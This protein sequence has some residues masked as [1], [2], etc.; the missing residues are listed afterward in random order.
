MLGS[1]I[2]LDTIFSAPA[3]CASSNLKVMR[4]YLEGFVI[5]ATMHHFSGLRRKDENL[6]IG[7]NKR[8][9]LLCPVGRGGF[10]CLK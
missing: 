2:F 5:G 9:S 4:S 3:C 6:G 10:K 8:H 1:A 7:L